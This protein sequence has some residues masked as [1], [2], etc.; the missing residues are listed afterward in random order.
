MLKTRTIARWSSLLL[1][2]GAGAWLGQELAFGRSEGDSVSKSFRT[3][4]AI[5]MDTVDLVLNGQ[6]ADPAMLGLPTDLAVT[7]GYLVEVLDEY[8]AVADGRPTEYLRSFE[9][10]E[11]WAVDP[12]GNESSESRDAL[13]GREVAYTWDD[14]EGEYLGSFVDPDGDAEEL[15]KVAYDM[16]LWGIL[17]ED[18]V[19][20]GST[21]TVEGNGVAHMLLPG[22]EVRSALESDAEVPPVI[23]DA[24]LEFLDDLQASAT[25]EGEEELDGRDCAVILLEAEVSESID[26]DPAAFGADMSENGME[27]FEASLDIELEIEAR[28]LWDLESGGFV[29][30]DLE[31]VGTLTLD[32]AV[33]VVEAGMDLEALAEFS[34]LLE[35]TAEAVAAE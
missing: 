35:Q 25:Y 29:T 2:L 4:V 23:R 1:T 6:A 13:V 5:E 12:E 32:A 27:D 21:W 15:E 16:D 33:N 22:L 19:E 7:A 3:E 26:I 11:S 31:G 17:P 14:D 30:F 8:V 28:C 9:G 10:F 34:I 20:A 18:E 24:V